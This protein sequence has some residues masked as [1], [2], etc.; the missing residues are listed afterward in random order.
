MECYINNNIGVCQY[1]INDILKFYISDFKEVEINY[2]SDIDKVID[3]FTDIEWKEIKFNTITI[4]TDEQGKIYSTNI[5][6]NISEINNEINFYNPVNKLMILF[7]DSN[8]NAW[9]DSVL[10]SD[11][12]YTFDNIVGNLGVDN[13]S[14]DFELNKSSIYNIK[15]IENKYL[16]FI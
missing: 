6:I 7:I 9:V 13:N 10:L 16:E 11:N 15:Q 14:I 3:I 4:L 8:Q 2:D 5:K 12:G 1:I